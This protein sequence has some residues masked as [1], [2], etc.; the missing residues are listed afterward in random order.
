MSSSHADATGA[1]DVPP[2]AKPGPSQVEGYARDDGDDDQSQVARRIEELLHGIQTTLFAQEMAAQQQ[3]QSI[4]DVWAAT[5]R[6][7]VAG[8]VEGPVPMA[9][10]AATVPVTPESEPG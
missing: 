4:A 6:Y 2:D 5:E 10:K 9:G 1:E 8:L 7:R 3:L